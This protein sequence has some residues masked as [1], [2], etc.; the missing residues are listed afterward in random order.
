MKITSHLTEQGRNEF[1]ENLQVI[2][3]IIEKEILTYKKDLI[4]PDLVLK[5]DDTLEFVRNCED[6]INEAIIGVQI[7]IHDPTINIPE[8]P[9]SPLN[10]LMP[11][12]IF[13][14]SYPLNPFNPASVLNKDHPLNP[15]NP[16]SIL[17]PLHPLNPSNEDSILHPKHPLNPANTSSCLNPSNSNYPWN[18]HSKLNPLN[19]ISIDVTMFPDPNWGNPA[20][21]PPIPAPPNITVNYTP[22]P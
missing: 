1:N 9:N 18:L 8:S 4:L 14:P 5:W 19:N 20:Y 6:I 12:S 3:E 7:T 17:H 22:F 21:I 2:M 10:P 15:A 13:D 11:G 16:N